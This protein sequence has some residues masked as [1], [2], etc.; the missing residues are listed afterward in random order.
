MLKSETPTSDEIRA[1]GY[2]FWCGIIEHADP[3]PLDTEVHQNFELGVVLRGQ[4][5]RYH[6]GY[7]AVANPG[8]IWMN[9]AWE[10]HAWR[11]TRPHTA[12]FVIY[13]LPEFLGHERI[14]DMSWL[15]PFAVP[16]RSRPGCAS[17]RMR[18]QAL[19][20]ARELV[21]EIHY[22]DPSWPE[23]ARLAVIR[24]LL[25]VTRYWMPPDG[26]QLPGFTYSQY[27]PRVLPAIDLVY[28]DATRQ[29]SLEEA[30]R[31]CKL[32]VSQFGYLF[33]RTMGQSFGK[34]CLRARL[35]QVVKRLL[36]TQMSLEAIA[37]E[38]GFSHASH[39]HRIFLK[40]YGC[41]PG[42]YR[43]NGQSLPPAAE[44]AE[45]SEAVHSAVELA[46]R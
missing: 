27:L 26:A 41:S 7:V 11:V 39:L 18:E 21:H 1:L 42:Q 30:S 22:Q 45:D 10:P 9:A 3:E 40:Y 37:S 4:I 16:A 8:D 29:V 33:R 32:S 15:A 28:P 25:L 31:A 23:A 44:E 20:I 17:A 19:A 24:L 46:R 38:C 13:F 34:F 12:E 36:N 35:L 14:A 2:P 5:E 43:A 6:E